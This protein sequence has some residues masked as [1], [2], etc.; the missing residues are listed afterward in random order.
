MFGCTVNRPLLRKSLA[1][2]LAMHEKYGV[3]LNP[4]YGY[5]FTRVGCFPCINS[6]KSE[7]RLISIHFP[8]RI[9]QLRTQEKNF[10]TFFARKTVP[11]RYRSYTVDTKKGPM[12]VATIDDVVRWSHTLKGAKEK[13]PTLWDDFYDDDKTL[14]CPSGRGMCE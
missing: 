8:E 10:S 12:K 11:E 7:V 14:V 13:T 1:D 5:G 2:V 3:P 9:D 4:L 6:N